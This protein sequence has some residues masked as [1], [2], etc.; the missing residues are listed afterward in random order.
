MMFKTKNPMTKMYRLK[1]AQKNL[2]MNLNILC[3]DQSHVSTLSLKF[4]VILDSRSSESLKND[5]F[6]HSS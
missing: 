4:L 5:V 6:D 1:I 3:H 2:N